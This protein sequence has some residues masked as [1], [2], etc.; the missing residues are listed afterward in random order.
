M[1]YTKYIFLTNKKLHEL[2]LNLTFS[3]LILCTVV[4]KDT[5]NLKIAFAN[6]VILENSLH[7]NLDDVKY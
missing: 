2:L 4:I 3:G 7:Q 6:I 1:R 5:L